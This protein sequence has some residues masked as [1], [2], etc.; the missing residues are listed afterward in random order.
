MKWGEKLKQELLR[1]A[2]TRENAR[3]REKL[4]KHYGMTEPYLKTTVPDHLEPFALR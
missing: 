2:N 4:R 1:E 3:Y